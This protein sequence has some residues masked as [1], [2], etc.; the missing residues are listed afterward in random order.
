MIPPW[1]KS[2]DKPKQCI[3]K[4]RHYFANKGS[5][6]QG[7]DFSISHV[8]MWEL[9]HKES[10]TL[11]N[12]FFWTVVL[13][14]TLES[15]LDCK[16]IKPINPKRNQPWIFI[17]RSGVEAE[18][19]VLGHLM[20]RANSL[21][22]TLMLGKIEGRRRRGQE[23]MRCLDGITDART[24]VWVNSRSWWWTGRPGMLRFM[25]SQS[26]RQDWVTEL[27]WTI[28]NLTTNKVSTMKTIVKYHFHLSNWPYGKFWYY[29][30]DWVTD[31]P[32]HY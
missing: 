17:G 9:D 22:K 28:L 6:R 19:P 4:Q 29:C 12:W 23:K 1:K 30:V 14:E 21:A 31:N 20:R 11:K 15:S 2:Y 24:W 10:W 32:I 16:E 26:V 18:T 8:W 13:E 25:G 5:S 7:Y 27:N 3:K